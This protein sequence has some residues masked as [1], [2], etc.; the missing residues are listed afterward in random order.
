[1]KTGHQRY[2]RL[3]FLGVVLA[4]LLALSLACG[5]EDTATPAAPAIPVPAEAPT[6]APAPQATLI[7]GAPTPVSILPTP[8]RVLPTATPV[9]TGGPVYG[10]VLRYAGPIDESLDPHFGASSG[11]AAGVHA[12]LNNLARI[13]FDGKMVPDLAQ[14]WELSSGGK[15]MTFHLQPGVKFHDGT[16][17]DAQAV[18][19]N[20]DR[21]LDPENVS[22]RRGE[23]LAF[24]IQEV[25]VVDDLTI[26]F[27]FPRAVRPFLTQLGDKAGWMVSPTAVAK[28]GEDFGARPVGTGAFVFK[29][30]VLGQRLI[31]E[32]NDNYWEKG[33]PYLDAIHQFDIDT[34]DLQLALLRTNE[35]DIVEAVRPADI[36]LIEANPNLR[37]SP[38]LAGRTDYL[39]FK[40]D[41]EPWTNKAL[42]QAIAYSIDRETVVDVVWQGRARPAHTF[43]QQGFAHDPSIKP[44]VYDPVK[45]REKLVEAGYPNGIKVTMG[46][47][48]SSEEQ[49]QAETYQAMMKEVGI[50]VEVL[51]LPSSQYF[52]ADGY[53]TRAGFGTLRTSPRMDPHVFLNRRV[54]SA[55][56]S[57]KDRGINIPEIDRLLDEA[58]AILDP[59]KAKPLYDRIQTI[60]AA[61][62]IIV[63]VDW[64][65]EFTAYNKKVQNFNWAPDRFHR[66]RFLWLE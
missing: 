18:K 21:M 30:W 56:G 15:L 22:P 49:L 46:S 31:M 62:A 54:S 40:I 47:R 36:P 26:A 2:L 58:I 60:L 50:D 41:L 1:M 20:F 27:H 32:R 25:E 8:T 34:L 42:R 35:A 28:L 29:E 43:I 51:L 53:L 55:V 63:F 23:L 39:D 12:M 52:G 11:S 24:D 6:V 37:L 9:V 13:D 48:T 65:Q 16:D 66:L 3:G 61:D 4:V 5:A 59:S 7:P 10:G 14:S 57:A 38:P 64:R 19:W 33:Q 17:F 45:A 44:I